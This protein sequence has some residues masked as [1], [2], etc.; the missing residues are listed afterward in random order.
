MI[1]QRF[2]NL[3]CVNNTSM[4]IISMIKVVPKYYY[5]T[6]QANAILD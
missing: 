1:K 4:W 6:I 5:A 2:Q 3:I